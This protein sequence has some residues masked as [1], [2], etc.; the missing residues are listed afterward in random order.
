[1]AVQAQVPQVQQSRLLAINFGI[2]ETPGYKLVH[3]SATHKISY[4]PCDQE[5][6]NFA[7][8]AR[9]RHDEAQ[10]PFDERKP[11]PFWT[12]PGMAD[13]QRALVDPAH[14]WHIGWLGFNYPCIWTPLGDINH[15]SMIA[16]CMRTKCGTRLCGFGPGCALPA[17]ARSW[18][19]TA[20]AAS[21]PPTVTMLLG[22]MRTKSR[23]I[24]D[25]SPSQAS[26]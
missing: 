12:V 14:T 11:S 15:F 25:P 6:H 13:P 24:S 1:M 19:R 26:K 22:A 16:T 17:E 3:D 20:E 4:R 9:W 2:V 21:Q 7:K 8:D 10:T 23:P 18:K 5:W